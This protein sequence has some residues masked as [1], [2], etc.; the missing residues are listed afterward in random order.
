MEVNVI[1]E[2][3]EVSRR[4]FRN[5]TFQTESQRSLSHDLPT[6]III[7]SEL[8]LLLFG[9]R[10]EK[11]KAAIAKERGG[12]GRDGLVGRILTG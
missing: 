4:K 7:L 2:E 11:E 9:A 1:E 12:E 8:L 6:M 5:R 10:G 3:S